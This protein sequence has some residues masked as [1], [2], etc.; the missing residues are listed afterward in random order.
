MS[1]GGTSPVHEGTHASAFHQRLP[2]EQHNNATGIPPWL[3]VHHMLDVIV[4][5][6]LALNPRS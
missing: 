5:L 3:N 1:V 4:P 6:V 2:L